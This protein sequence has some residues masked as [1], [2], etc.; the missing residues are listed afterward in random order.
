[1]SDT[2]YRSIIKAYSYRICGSLTT[3]VISYIVTGKIVVS[4]TIGASE[5]VIKPFVYW[6]HERVWNQIKFGRKM[7]KRILIMG[8]PGSGKT[9]LAKQLQ[10]DLQAEGK[11]VTWLNADVVREQ[12]NDWDFSY[13]GRI[14]QSVRMRQLAEHAITDYV[15]CDFVAPLKEMRRNFSAHHTIWVD[16]LV[17]SRFEDTDKMFEAPTNYDVKVT[18][19]NAKKW[20]QIVI[21]HIK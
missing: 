4:L 9:T 18:E 12:F 11:T 13:E 21:Q 14:R 10:S 8:L 2:R 17:N 7:A 20:S 6:M 1:M 5:L 15:I 16:T 3:M 19:Q